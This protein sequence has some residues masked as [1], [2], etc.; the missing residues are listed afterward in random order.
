VSLRPAPARQHTVRQ[1]NL[2]LV[3]QHIAGEGPLSRA[4]IASLTGLTRATV[5]SLVDDLMQASLVTE[6]GPRAG[7][8]IGRPGRALTANRSSYAGLGLEV[9]VDYIAV[10]VTDLAGEVRYLRTRLADNR[11][12]SPG[13]VL[14]RA[15]RIARTA[16]KAAEAEQLTVAGLAIAL[17]GLV[18]AERGLLR[19]AP[20]LGWLDVPVVEFLSV[21]LEAGR[22][23]VT[24]DNEANLAALG[25]LWF[26]GHDGLTD[27]VYVSGEIGVGAGIVIGRELFRGVMG[28]AGE[29]GHVTVQPDGPPCRCGSRGCLEQVAGQEAIMRAAGLTGEAGTSM[30]QPGGSVAELVARARSGEARTLEAIEAAGH[31]LGIG[32]AAL[33]NLVDPTTVVLGGLYTLLEPWLRT[34]FSEELRARVISQRWS[35][36]RVLTSRLGPDAAVRGA[37]G[38]VIRKILSHPEVVLVPHQG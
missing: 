3:L 15:V 1:H 9:N 20:N 24:V 23:P 31:A 35:R 33:V 28:F 19:V 21:R 29:V 4:R 30:G 11:R 25:E 10:C 26:G 12:L 32:I 2:A 14:S 5:S 18:E 27:F 34:P 13:R 17:P 16:V 38:T 6:L 36:V 37:A 8:G 7:G 22:L